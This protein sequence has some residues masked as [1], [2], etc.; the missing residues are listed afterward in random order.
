MLILMML[1]STLYCKLVAIQDGQY[2]VYVFENLNEEST[3][4]SKYIMCTKLPNWEYSEILQ[5]GDIGFLQCEFTISGESYYKT[6]T[7]S[8]EIYKYTN[9]YFINFIKEKD[10]TINKEFNF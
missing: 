7:N 8:N 10:K 4:K 9:C 3:S 5:T 6:S 1:I 2:T